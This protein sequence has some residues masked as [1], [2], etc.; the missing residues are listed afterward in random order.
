MI[1]TL[2]EIPGV[3]ASSARE[4][5]RNGINTVAE[6]AEAEV[7]DLVPLRGFGEVRAADVIA[8]AKRIVAGDSVGQTASTPAVAVM[9]AE[10]STDPV[11]EETP[12]AEPS[13]PDSDKPKEPE[14]NKKGKKAKK[15]GK[16]SKK[17]GNEK[18]VKTEKDSKKKKSKK[19]GKKGKKKKK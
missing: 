19:K 14:K 11:R 16:K 2:R 8:A 5:I 4:L 15:K 9:Q 1:S 17:K 7:A 6:V 18:K 3:G 10:E 13:S 12:P